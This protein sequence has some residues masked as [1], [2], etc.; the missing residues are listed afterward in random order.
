[1]RKQPVAE[2]VA[3]TLVTSADIKRTPA[4][5]TWDEHEAADLPAEREASGEQ[6]K[7]NRELV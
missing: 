5:G 3:R 6:V 4:T 2:S 1:M 7:T